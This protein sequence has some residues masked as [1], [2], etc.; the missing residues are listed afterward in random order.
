MKKNIKLDKKLFIILITTAT[1]IIAD[2]ITKK[3]IT[4]FLE[5]SQSISLINNFLYLTLIHN[6]GAAFGMLQN[7]TS[8]LIWISVIAIGVILYFYEKIPKK[9]SII[10]Y[11]SFILGGTI[12]NL[13]DRI[14]LGYVIDFIDFGIWPAFNIADSVITIGAI[15]LIIYLFRKK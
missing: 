8:M 2:Q 15:G 11:V 12:S 7:T 9:T 3:L 1:I 13:I 14:R 5:F 4:H 6:Y 10:I